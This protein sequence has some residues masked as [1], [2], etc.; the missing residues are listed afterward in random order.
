[1]KTIKDF[2][3]GTGP[4]VDTGYRRGDSWVQTLGPHSECGEKIIV[5]GPGIGVDTKGR[6]GPGVLVRCRGCMLSWV[7]R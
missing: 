7:I 5:V 2:V 1:M 3:R 6:V 4:E